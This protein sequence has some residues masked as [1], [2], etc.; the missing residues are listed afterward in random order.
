MTFFEKLFGT[1]SERELKLL[2]KTIDKIEGLRDTMVSMSDEE[3]RA[4]TQEFK[5]RLANGETLDDI[6]VEAFAVVREA[7]RRVLDKELYRVQLQG[8]VILHQG[9]IAEMNTGEGKANPINTPIPTPEGWKTVGDIKVGD[10]LFDRCGYPTKVTGVFP[11]GKI[12]VYEV[13]LR[14]GRTVRCAADHLWEVHRNKTHGKSWKTKE[15]LTTAEIIEA[16]VKA[17]RGYTFSIPMCE[18]VKYDAKELEINPYV[19][20]CFLGDGCK[21]DTDSLM[22][23]SQDEEII[24]EVARLIGAEGY[25]KSSENNFNWTFDHGI[26]TEGPKNRV[27]KRKLYK[28]KE[29]S[30]KY[31][32]LLTGTYCGDKYIPMEYKTSSVEQRWELLQGI[33][34]TD[35]NIYDGTSDKDNRY[36]IQYS[37]TSKQL[38]DDVMEVIYSLGLS[39]TCNLSKKAGSKEQYKSD[40]YMIRVNVPNEIKYKFFRLGRKKQI[41]EEAA[42]FNRRKDYNFISIIDIKKLD[43]QEEQIC[44]TVENLERLFL[45]DQYVVTHNT[46]TCV[47]PC[48]L[49]ALE[50]KGVHVVTVNDYLASRDAEEMGRIHR[51]LGLT[52]SCIVQGMKPA[53]RKAAYDCD[54]TYITNSELGFD[55][56]R[57]NMAV[58]K[59]DLVQ[60][61]LHYCIIDEVDSIL[62]DEA[63]TP[64]IISGQS[65]KSTKLYEICN[66]LALRMKQGKYKGELSKMDIILKENLEEDGEFIVNEKDKIVTLTEEG[67]KRVEK[68]FHITNLADVENIEIQHGIDIALKAN[69]LFHKD[70]NYIVADDGEVQIVDEFTGRIM[71]GRRFSDGIHQAIEAKEHVKIKQESKTLATITYQN[72]FNKYDKKSG[73]TGTA[74]TEEEEFRGIYELD[75]VHVPTNRPLARIDH[76][77][78][79]FKTKKEKYN[80]IVQ[81]VKRSY[82]IGQPVLV[83]TITIDISELLS[84]MLKKE[85]IPHQVLNAKYHAQEAEI[86]KL[87]GQKGAVTIATNMAGR[88][89]DI[90]LGDDVA[91]L[92]GLKI[93]GTERHE[94]R[95]IDNQLRGRS[96]RQG[97]IGESKF[98][99]SLEDDLMRLFGSE[100]MISMFNTLGIPEGEEI[101]HKMLSNA[102]ETAQKRI[103]SN[104]Y[105]I[106]KR[107][108]DFDKTN[109]EQREIIYKERRRVL[110]GDNLRPNIIS[111]LE[112]VVTAIVINHIGEGDKSEWDL[113]SLRNSLKS[114]TTLDGLDFSNCET[115]EDVVEYVKQKAVELYEDKEHAIESVNSEAMRE[116]ERVFL[117]RIVDRKWQEHIDN[118][119]QLK[120]GIGLQ[121]YGQKDPVI[122]YK[123]QS[124]DIF[125][126]LMEDIKKE[127]IKLI[128]HSRIQKAEEAQAEN[129]MS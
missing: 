52:V 36:N 2:D 73:M 94:S 28:G 34:D 105:G 117:L 60:R 46:L 110:E 95:R 100:K 89:T 47:A 71:P 74:L 8:G 58:R 11:Q 65:G 25:K 111:M 75:V 129:L 42:K 106:R 120:Q 69:Y 70:Q 68:F 123:M 35:G 93:I 104:H 44:F 109:N 21:S 63:R 107:V 97:D 96:G 88:G 119:E 1:H 50:G 39:C 61:G 51:F 24:A 101:Q 45:I 30:E 4:K 20:G 59:E 79:V 32:K 66:M 102:I 87:A 6:L 67:V 72:F 91:D 49:N 9:R 14:D 90:K 56:L 85:G 98:Y 10:M 124:Y 64:L 12:D 76:N 43:I 33:F 113:E 81:E 62:I 23:S 16:G 92:G 19:L 5:D 86:V 55:Y 3:L 80:A 15:V 125:D 108:L 48:Y 99:I 29:L 13:T 54:I 121:A 17:D 128:M 26:L 7:G 38:C 57:D 41:A 118:M 116:L 40:Q 78:A 84:D 18:E 82:K 103:E 53:E 77:D 112:D 37:T 126:E 115:A 31:S 27:G 114:E 127:T 122:E 22:M 83:G